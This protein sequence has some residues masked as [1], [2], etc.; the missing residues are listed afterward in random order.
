MEYAVLAAAGL[1]AVNQYQT[2]KFQKTMYNLQAQQ[3]ELK[4]RADALRFNQQALA[5]LE[6]QRRTTAALVARSASAGVDPFTGSPMDV[7]RWNAYQAGEEYNILDENA[8]I[9]IAGGLARSQSL[10]AAGDQALRSA[11]IGA[12]TTLAMGAY[13]YSQ[14]STPGGAGIGGGKGAGD[15]FSFNTGGN[16]YSVFGSGNFYPVPKA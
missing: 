10:Q 15:A 7:D 11:K 5:I 13:S 4:G 8:D 3:E 16:P 6:T 1:S 14:L 12:L 9:A 2:G